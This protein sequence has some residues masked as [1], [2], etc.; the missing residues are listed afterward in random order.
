MDRV[1]EY[2]IIEE[3]GRGATSQVFKACRDSDGLEVALKVFRSGLW[4]HD[5]ILRRAKR[6]I[7]TVSSL[8]HPNI[9]R[10]VESLWD[11][12]P[13]AVAMDL[14]RGSSLQDFQ[15]RLPYILPEVGVLIMIE[16][17]SALEHAHGQGVIH[18]DL[19]PANI[20]VSEEGGIFVTDFGLAKINDLSQV[21]ATGA[22][23]GSPAYMSPEQARGDVL[24]PHSDLFSVAAILYFLVTGIPPFHRHSP[25]ATLA[26]VIDAKFEAPGQ[27]NP[28][29]SPALSKLIA[30]GL[31]A[32]PSQRFAS[33]SA[34]REALQN[35]LDDLGLDRAAFTLPMWIKDSA[36]ITVES[37]K[38]MSE[39]LV[40]RAEDLLSMGDRDAF[41]ETVS[42]ISQVA[43]ETSA[44]PR[45]FEAADKA[46]RRQRWLRRG[47]VALTAGV[48]LSL[49]ASIYALR[50]PLMNW[51]GYG[52]EPVAVTSETRA[53]PV[54]V[55]STPTS[56]VVPVPA[57]KPAALTPVT[58]PLEQPAPAKP[59]AV[60]EI[61]PAVAAKKKLARTKPKPAKKFRVEPKKE[62]KSMVGWIEFDVPEN[63][64]VYVDG[65]KV[66]PTRPLRKVPIGQHKLVLAKPGHQPI[67]GVVEVESDEPTVVRVR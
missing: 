38:T 29:L 3:I 61:K 33:A 66:D 5:S 47:A 6:E 37:L 62:L 26:A 52:A 19:K 54:A 25:L 15:P 50:R 27:R 45:L 55:A 30:K 48:L 21:T 10:I 40:G 49:F 12:E 22:I 1:A 59:V 35:Y 36:S 65:R 13:P 16:V 7:D 67:A 46:D 42:H 39:R 32:E 64:L 63:V 60:A 44:I 14:I 9:V 24:T 56:A 8:R 2:R 31:S 17:L 28:K 18:R 34:F 53:E 43:P 23:L 58:K 4:D 20:L 11:A 51:V 41:L 57:T